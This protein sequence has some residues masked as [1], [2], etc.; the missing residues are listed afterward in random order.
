MKT[1]KAG[2]ARAPSLAWDD[3]SRGA[4]IDKRYILGR[5]EVE[6]PRVTAS[7][8]K[9]AAREERA[10]KA[11]VRVDDRVSSVERSRVCMPI[12]MFVVEA[13]LRCVIFLLSSRDVSSQASVCPALTLASKRRNGEGLEPR[14]GL[15]S[16]PGSRTRNYFVTFAPA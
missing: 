7:P 11:G 10:S 14:L 13:M 12:F 1:W 9:F 2:L 3:T 16:S 15:A 6:R 8:S 4:G 5:Q